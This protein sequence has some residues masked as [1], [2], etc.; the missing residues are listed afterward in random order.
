MRSS[1]SANWTAAV[2]ATRSTV[3]PRGV[4]TTTGPLGQGV[5][6]S[7]GMA[8]AGL[9]M[10]SRFNQPGFED[11][12]DFDVYA[13]CGDG[14]M[15][16]GVTNEAASLAGHLKLS[17][18][19][20]IYDNNKITIEGHTA[21]AFSDDVATRFLGY[22][23]NVVRVGDANDL[24]MLDRAFRT[25]H[26]T[27]DRPT[28]MIVDSHI[29]FGSPNKQDTSGA[30][31][32]PL[33]VE[34]V[35]LTKKRYGWPEDAQFHVPNGVRDHF[36]EGMGD[37]GKS[38]RDTWFDRV[39]EY[40]SRYPELAD[41]LLSNAAPPASRGAGTGSCRISLRTPRECQAV[42]PRVRC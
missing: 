1:S 37:R 30:H 41:N 19:C 40:R 36:R 25:F 4:E 14:C 33:G 10:A 29:G 11:L 39:E 42:T 38:L 23:W 3:G 28:L 20:W 18:L 12:V 8:I 21:L 24:E 15:M 5:A 26:D 32:E 6:T 22:G 9:W 2:P 17:K 7:V 16:E 13:L 31:G 27:T 34:E 35:K